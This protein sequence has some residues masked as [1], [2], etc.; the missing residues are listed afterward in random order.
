MRKHYIDNI[1]WSAI[2]V[3][4]IYHAAMAFNTLG[5]PNYITLHGSRAVISIVVFQSPFLMPLLF[6]L[7]G[8][9][10]KYSL[11]RRTASEYIKE[12]VTKLLIPLTFTTF[13]ILPVMTYLADR[14]NCGYS[15]SFVLHYKVFFTRLTDMTGA[16]GGFSVGHLW[17]LAYLFVISCLFIATSGLQKRINTAVL[18]S[19][20]HPTVMI[21][22]AGLPIIV[23]HELLSIGGKSI[24]EY[25]YLFMLGYHFFS[26]DDVIG[27]L[28]A[29]RRP[30]LCAGLCVSVLNTYLFLWCDQDTA[31]VRAANTL[32][33]TLAEW[34]MLLAVTGLAKA[35]FDRENTVTRYMVQ[36]SFLFYILHYIWIVLF[37]Y[38]LYDSLGGNTALMFLLPLLP[39]YAAT[40]ISCEICIHIPVLCLLLGTKPAGRKSTS[41]QQGAKP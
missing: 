25:L 19:S 21:L 1:R 34:L 29:H 13:T 11:C 2:S 12:R 41:T 39:A 9:S 7:A 30:M 35:R 3:L 16:D 36:R 17:F 27:N 23:F 37:Q 14:F 18:K 33:R 24:L 31:A 32:T 4:I 10:T 38:I 15:G 28:S 5:E 6:L 40:L 22:L 26:D 20:R 8:V